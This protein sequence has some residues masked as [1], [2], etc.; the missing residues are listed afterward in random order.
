[1]KLSI[2]RKLIITSIIAVLFAIIG[3]N[4]VFALAD[5]TGGL[6]VEFETESEYALGERIALPSVNTEKDYEVCVLLDGRVTAVYD[7]AVNLILE[8]V[9]QYEIIYS[10]SEENGY[11]WSKG[12]KFNCVEKPYIEVPE[13]ST[14]MTVFDSVD[15]EDV[16]LVGAGN[17]IAAEVSA[18][19]PDG[20]TYAVGKTFKPEKKGV[21]KLIFTANHNGKSYSKSV[22]VNVTVDSTDLFE[23]VNGISVIQ[24]NT[25]YPDWVK[26]YPTDDQ[27]RTGGVM[28]LGKGGSST[29]RYRNKIDLNSLD[30]NQNL[31]KFAVLNG[32]GYADFSW[33]EAMHVRLIDA[34]DSSRVVTVKLKQSVD[35]ATNA[36]ITAS[37]DGK[38]WYGR[39]N[40]GPSRPMYVNSA[41]FFGFVTTAGVRGVGGSFQLAYNNATNEVLSN[42][43]LS[44]LPEY[45]D[46]V[47]LDDPVDVGS[48]VFK[49]FTTGEIYLEVEFPTL[50]TLGGVIVSEIAG[51]SLYGESIV[52][53]TSP[54]LFIPETFTDTIPVGYVGSRYQL[55][56]VRAVDFVSGETNVKIQLTFGGT[57]IELENNSFVPES[58]G[59]YKYKISSADC[60][61]NLTEKEI[62]ISVKESKTEITAN[63]IEEEDLYAGS[64]ISVPK[65]KVEGGS[66]NL[67]VTYRL[68]ING[69]EIE[70]DENGC[71]F[72][73]KT[74]TFGIEVDVEDYLG[75]KK[76]ITLERD[77]LAPDKTVITVKGIPDAA[78]VGD[79]LNLSNFSVTDYTINGE[80]DNTYKAVFISGNRVNGEYTVKDT[81]GNY[82]DVEFIGGKGNRQNVVRKRIEIINS[83]K[84]ENYYLTQGNVTKSVTE[85][86][87]FF[88]SET[89]FTVKHPFAISASEFP[90]IVGFSALNADYADIVLEDYDNP[91]ITVFFRISSKSTNKMNLQINGEGIVYE[92]DGSF[93]NIAKT[94]SLIYNNANYSLSQETGGV[95]TKIEYTV[96]GK[97]FNGFP[98][99][100][101]RFSIHVKGVMGN[102]GV[103]IYKLSNQVLNT[104]ALDIGVAPVVT[105]ENRMISKRV[106]LGDEFCVSSLVAVDVLDN[107]S[108]AYVTM[109]DP[110]G[111]NVLSYA[112]CSI[113]RWYKA[114]QYGTYRITYTVVDR[115]GNERIINYNVVVVD[116][117]APSLKINSSI[118]EKVKLGESIKIPSATYSDEL[119]PNAYI[120]IYV[121]SLEDMETYAVR[122]GEEIRFDRAGRY[123]IIYCVYDSQ[124]NETRKTIEF[125]VE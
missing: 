45:F 2:L 113:S 48:N 121:E 106:S 123:L 76:T 102:S 81:D 58:A 42:N 72:L 90:F 101:I 119:D 34:Y 82:I 122:M 40:E 9:G 84:L 60:F 116:T 88:Y 51:Q 38:N 63:F 30:I 109:K 105:F 75:E 89:D 16:K 35:S 71:V 78:K 111:K 107:N 28:I 31:I 117:V 13:I 59:I 64:L 94:A 23:N 86:G 95:L 4:T 112:D 50:A 11:I 21:Y 118:K 92:I 68:Y 3:F 19:D 52:D 15:F 80:T 120:C 12:F 20:K 53:N 8:K 39:S 85:D 33:F 74:G 17:G 124:Y 44:W 73:D 47:D 104:D 61:G 57:P 54:T 83:E 91:E 66:T 26:K 108:D 32:N 67:S 46:V 29:F 18:I 65:F 6:E 114:D 37:I 43:G 14:Q 62:E 56:N 49:G 24:G 98:S 7:E 79:K 69:Q 87:S 41:N 125:T 110:T 70:E 93:E 97:K 1:M 22:T 10:V 55:P 5:K 27:D 99:K 115:S 96:N 100:K 103:N 25:A 36:Y 77:I